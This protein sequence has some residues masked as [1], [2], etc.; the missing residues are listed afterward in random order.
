MCDNLTS[1]A[2]ASRRAR[3]R[4]PAGNALAEAD[5]PA[6]AAIAAMAAWFPVRDDVEPCTRSIP[7]R[8]AP[9][10]NPRQKGRNG[11]LAR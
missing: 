5:R 11:D 10:F 7:L 4:R 1:P 3:F 8:H 6:A 2:L 9:R